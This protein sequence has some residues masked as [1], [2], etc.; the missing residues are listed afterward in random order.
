MQ[1][2]QYSIEIRKRNFKLELAFVVPVLSNA[3]NVVIYKERQRIEQ[4]ILFYNI[5]PACALI[6]Q[7]PIVAL[8]KRGITITITILSSFGCFENG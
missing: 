4:R 2:T 7:K 1:K 8:R 5:D 6:G 3:Q